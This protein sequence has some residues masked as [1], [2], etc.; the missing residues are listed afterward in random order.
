MDSRIITFKLSKYL[1]LLN[2]P[3]NARLRSALVDFDN[4]V[5]YGFCFGLSVCHA[6]MAAIDKLDWWEH[7][8]VAISTWDEKKESLEEEIN[9]PGS[10]NNKSVKLEEIFK[11]VLDYIIY[12]HGIETIAEFQS[13]EVSQESMLQP[14]KGNFEIVDERKDKDK[15]QRI[16]ERK[17]FA[18]YLSNQMIE[19]MLDEKNLED[20]LCLI[21]S[22]GHTFNIVFKN[23]KWILYDSGDS[24]PTSIHKIHKEFKTKK[25]LIN[26]LVGTFGHSLAIEIASFKENKILLPEIEKLS[27]EE[28]VN[29]LNQF[30]LNQ[31]I[32]HTPEKLE[33]IFKMAENSDAVS[34][35]IL[36]NLAKRDAE[37]W[38]A[39]NLLVRYSPKHL[40]KLLQIANKFPQA[41]NVLSDALSKRDKGGYTGL[42]FVARYAPEKLGV[43]LEI[44]SKTKEGII[45]IVNVLATTTVKNK[46]GLEGFILFAPHHLSQLLEHF[47]LLSLWK[48]LNFERFAS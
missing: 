37:S 3:E 10:L 27:E 42:L 26:E 30:G 31:I 8:L 28:L 5:R 16:K 11:R 33:H 24:D 44:L 23:N 47:C 25:A 46:L 15:I 6:A 17:F 21:H 40:D 1:E 29:C 41:S 45:N 34:K 12:S 9:L 13:E 2:L 22:P 20:A 7:A 48:R 39:F 32:R 35:A 38:T 43:F 14:N 4:P 18:G 19:Q 36:I